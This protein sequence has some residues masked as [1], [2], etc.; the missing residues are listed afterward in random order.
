MELMEGS[1]TSLVECGVFE[2]EALADVVFEHT[3][4]GLKRLA[5]AGIIHGDIKP[6][7]ILNSMRN[8]IYTFKITDFGLAN[9]E[10][11][12]ETLV[13]TEIY[14]APEIVT[15]GAKQTH[16][17]DVWSLYVTMIWALNVCGFRLA[18]D[19]KRLRTR[20]DIQRAI[21]ASKSDVTVQAIRGMAEVSP[22]KRPSAADMLD[23]LVQYRQTTN[24]V[25]PPR[26]LV[27]AVSQPL[28]KRPLHD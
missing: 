11:L 19:C 18:L 8:N 10:I 16:K 2:K 28:M 20:K 21:Q 23:M 6:D 26:D 4:R 9:F 1:L 27:E 5:E 14:L 12:A 7:N 13:G 15:E 22:E 25:D 17:I 24:S 3:L